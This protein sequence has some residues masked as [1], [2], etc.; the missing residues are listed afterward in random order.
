MSQP[1]KQPD[2]VR[3]ESKVRWIMVG[4]VGGA[5]L[6]YF[7]VSVFRTPLQADTYTNSYSTSPGGHTALI[8]LLRKSGREVT[9]G[10]A[11]LDLPKFDNARTDTLA[12][13]EPGMQY[14][15]HFGEEFAALFTAA[16]EESTSM[17]IAFPKRHYELMEVEEGGDVVLEEQEVSIFEVQSI[18]KSTGFD[19]WLDVDRDTARPEVVWPENALQGA[20]SEA[21]FKPAD[22]LQAFVVKAGK[23]PQNF[24]VLAATE[25]GAPVIVRY[26][27]SQFESTGGVVL[28]SDPDLLANRF[29]AEPGAAEIAA[30]L[31]DQTPRQGAILVDEDLHGFST[32][33]S[34]EYL[35]ATPP[36]L[37]V[38]LSSFL[39]LVIFAWRQATVLRPRAA[40]PQDRR[41]RKFSIEGL[42]RM[43]ERAGEH[44]AAQRRIMRRSRLVLG[45]G[46]TE[47]QGAGMTGTRTIQKGKTGRITRIQGASSEERLINAARKVAHQKRTG[48][49]EHSDLSFE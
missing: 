49:T 11:H 45:G 29:I 27:L 46:R 25:D 48:E 13:L 2:E 8:E 43:M 1:D 35:A 42:A 34:L 20:Q 40:E 36:G 22:Y 10:K 23:L 24:E 26:R 39:L 37:W 16:R 7:V 32:E 12:M 15:D 19:Q 9:P 21:R 17:L 18:L 31:F 6:L 14:V 3:S 30:R 41:A 38:T 44:D 5:M 4:V 28:V 47:V 33:A